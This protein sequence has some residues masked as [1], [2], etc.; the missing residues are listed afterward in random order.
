MLDWGLDSS[1]V[2]YGMCLKW[3]QAKRTRQNGN[4]LVFA[5]VAL[6]LA[7]MG[8]LCLRVFESLTI[9]V[10]GLLQYSELVLNNANT[11]F[12][13]M[14]ELCGLLQVGLFLKKR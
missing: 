3:F 6:F 2:M 10:L 11:C 7:E 1:G 4:G 9:R 12:Y 13:Q 5:E 8:F 14:E